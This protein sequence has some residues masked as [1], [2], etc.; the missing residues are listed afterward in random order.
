MKNSTLL[1]ATIA[2]LGALATAY[3]FIGGT[4]PKTG[5]PNPITVDGQTINF[6]WTDDNTDE[7]LHIWTDQATYTNGLSHA[8]VYVAV[9]NQSG[10]DQEVELMAHFRNSQK[11]IEDVQVLSEV[12]SERYEPILENRC[13]DQKTATGTVT[14]CNDVQVGTSTSLETRTQ[15]VPLDVIPRT[16]LELSKELTRLQGET[17]KSVE[18]FIAETKTKGYT[19][20]AGGVVYYKV[21]VVFPPNDDD[22]FYFTAIGSLGAKGHLDPWFDANWQY[23][24]KIE[25]NPARVGT[26][27]AVTNFPVYLDLGGLPNDFWTNAS[28]TGADIRIV[29]SDEVTETAF[30]L[31]SYNASTKRGELHFLADSLA[32]T[33]TSTFYLYYGN[34]S[35][36]AYA[37]TDTY[38]R[39]AV[40]TTYTA[41]YHFEG[42][43]TTD[44]TG[45]GKTLT[46]N[47]PTA[48]TSAGQ[49]GTSLDFGATN[50]TKTMS[51]ND[52]LGVDGG[53]VTMTAWYAPN[54]NTG[55]IGGVVETGNT[56][57][58][59]YN[60]MF[61]HGAVPAS[62]HNRNRSGVDDAFSDVAGT[63]ASGVFA[64]GAYVYDGSTL[65]GYRNAF[66]AASASHSGNGTSNIGTKSTIGKS[67][68]FGAFFTG[69][70]DEVRFATSTRSLAFITTEYNNQSA[71]STFF[72]IGPQ[73][74]DTPP[75][76]GDPVPQTHMY[77]G[78]NISGGAII[79]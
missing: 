79:R 16:S 77:G 39:N 50:S 61:Y 69:K 51:I 25:V 21:H 20:P 38:G 43:A 49:I 26:T 76:S 54:S 2:T 28:S 17:M 53:S 66:A 32:T 13:E 65:R 33:S 18:G 35:A 24:V 7:T 78:I 23:R 37:V 67:E 71:T 64:H 42:V 75:P 70:I 14:Y 74:E 4:D 40:W 34:P 8:D 27:S 22:N 36:S 12:T 58:D 60:G 73:E 3:I 6:T 63:V 9:I 5:A 48:T 62:W 46:N 44:S 72:Y 30:E 55:T 52:G 57:S 1:L 29:E 11:R 19:V 68:R 31:V 47:G 10:V 56:G 59:V 45:N 15:W 41:V